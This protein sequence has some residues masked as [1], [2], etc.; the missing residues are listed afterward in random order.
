MRR[1]GIERV[2][3]REDSDTI[4]PV[5]KEAIEPMRTEIRTILY[6]RVFETDDG[7]VGVGLFC[8]TEGL[9]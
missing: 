6:D 3:L 7:F 1:L 9:P 2:L 8:M 5:K 4:L